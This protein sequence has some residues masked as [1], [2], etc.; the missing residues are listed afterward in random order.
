M[1]DAAELELERLIAAARQELEIEAPG[2]MPLDTLFD[3]AK[4]DIAAV[5]LGLARAL[6]AAGEVEHHLEKCRHCNAPIEKFET[7]FANCEIVAPL[8]REATR[9]RTETLADF[10]MLTAEITRDRTA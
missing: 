6:R 8:D 7:A 4:L 9:L 1:S 3:G 5:A 10:D 2:P